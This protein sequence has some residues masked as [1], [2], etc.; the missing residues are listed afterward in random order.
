MHPNDTPGVETRRLGDLLGMRVV[1]PGGQELGRVSDARLAP[2][3]AVNG[4]RAELLVDGFL[5]SHGHPGSLLGYDRRERQGPAIV[6]WIVRAIQQA[7]Y[8][9]WHD[10]E[11]VDWNGRAIRLRSAGT[12][13]LQSV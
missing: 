3:P 9:S 2:G 11:K 6:R 1:A 8:V 7:R 13:P 12:S 10:V 5:V 4:A